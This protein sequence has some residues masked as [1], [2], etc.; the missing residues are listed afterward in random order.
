[1]CLYKQ[2][3][4]VKIITCLLGSYYMEDIILGPVATFK[5][6]SARLVIPA[7]RTFRK[8]GAAIC[9]PAPFQEIRIV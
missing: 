4:Y 7:L 9:G 3:K 6:R 1:M 5:M 2:L 8:P